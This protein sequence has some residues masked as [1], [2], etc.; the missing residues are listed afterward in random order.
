MKNLLVTAAVALTSIVATSQIVYTDITDV[1]ATIEAQ[2]AAE[3]IAIDFNNDGTEEY[4]FRWDVF[5]NDMWFLHIT[6]GDDNEINR[7]EGATPM[8]TYVEPMNLNDAIN[9]GSDWGNSFPEPFIADSFD[10]NFKGLGD[11]YIGTKF[12]IN[13]N[14]H[15][16][17]IL[18][19]LDNNFLFTVKSYAYESTANTAINAG[20]TGNTAGRDT[21]AENL[22][23]IYPNPAGNTFTVQGLQD[24]AIKS[25]VV[26]D[27]NGRKI[28]EIYP[29]N[30]AFPETVD[31]SGLE[32]GIYILNILDNTNR[33]MSQKL[34]KQ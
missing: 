9:I 8:E 26:N 25:V 23:K 13:G 29:A 33:M 24:F 22:I 16:G 5:N 1:S 31:I 18:V 4:N 27:L 10:T 28:T 17:W 11:R 2:N 30:K 19:S 3:F 7:K 12:T 34:V 32:S 15:Y 21:M 20:E 14:V 6:F